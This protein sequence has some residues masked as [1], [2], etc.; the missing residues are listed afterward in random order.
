MGGAAAPGFES[1]R[2]AAGEEV[3]DAR[4]GDEG[5][6]RGKDGGAHFF[7]RGA[8]V[9]GGGAEEASAAEV[10]RKIDRMLDVA[11][12]RG[13]WK[14][15]HGEIASVVP[16]GMWLVRM[17]PVL[18]SS[19]N[20]GG[21]GNAAGGTDGAPLLSAVEIEGAGYLDKNPNSESIDRFRDALRALPMFSPEKTETTW[22]P[23]ARSDSSLLEFRI[24][25]VLK[26]PKAL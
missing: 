18:V 19:G 20:A 5:G 2:A 24:M 6:K 15:I 10:E 4:A 22:Q 3:E 8:R 17:R 25:A 16:D 9:T 26:E 1:Q 7:L 21:E 11:G 13:V 23:P 12:R 14:A